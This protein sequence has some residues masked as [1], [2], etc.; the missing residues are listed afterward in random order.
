MDSID[1]PEARGNLAEN[2][3]A[4]KSKKVKRQV[5]ALRPIINDQRRASFV[6]RRLLNGLSPSNLPWFNPVV[7]GRTALEE[8]ANVLRGF[9]NGSR[10]SRQIAGPRR[11]LGGDVGGQDVAT[12]QGTRLAPHSSM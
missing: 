12:R 6:A 10:A 11:V 2:P 9:G 7:V 8:G 4:G 1:T 5:A 3:V